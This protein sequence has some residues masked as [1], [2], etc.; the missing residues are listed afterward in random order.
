MR[1]FDIKIEEKLPEFSIIDPIITRYA[2]D[3]TFSFS[4]YATRDIIKETLDPYIHALQTLPTPNKTV[5]H[6]RQ[7]IKQLMEDFP[8]IIFNTTDNFDRKYLIDRIKEIRKAIK[9]HPKLTEKEKYAYIKILDHY[10]QQIV[11]STRNINN[12]V[13]ELIKI[14]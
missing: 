5:L 4:H 14:I 6:C 3:I 1:K 13:E 2:D 12:I 11:T 8:Q 10:K 9:D 7:E